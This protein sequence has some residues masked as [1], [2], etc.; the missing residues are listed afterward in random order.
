MQVVGREKFKAGHINK[1]DGSSNPE[2]FIQV[3]H[4]I[5]EVTRGDDRVKANYLPTALAGTARSW[6]INLS[7]GSIYTWDQLCAMFLRNFQGTYEHS[8]T[9]ETLMTIRQKHDVS[10]RD[11]VKCFCNARNAIPYI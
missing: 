4:T 9:A 7:K 1:Y 3:Y 5:I 2:K 6:L 8:S 10:L 11:Y